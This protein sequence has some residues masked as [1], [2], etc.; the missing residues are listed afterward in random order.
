MARVKA[1]YLKCDDGYTRFVLLIGKL[2]PLTLKSIGGGAVVV[3]DLAG[4]LSRSKLP[5]FA[6]ISDIGKASLQVQFRLEQLLHFNAKCL[7]SG[8]K[9]KLLCQ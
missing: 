3:C 8:V 4:I 9:L 2:H 5:K 6:V 7:E 1:C